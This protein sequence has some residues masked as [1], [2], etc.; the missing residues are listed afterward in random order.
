MRWEDL[1]EEEFPQKYLDEFPLE[2]DGYWVGP[3]GKGLKGVCMAYLP[4]VDAIG[5]VIK[6]PEKRLVAPYLEKG[7]H[8]YILKEN[9]MNALQAA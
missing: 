9:M 3:K 2:I 6:Y 5:K 7:Q 1:T 4:I 8:V